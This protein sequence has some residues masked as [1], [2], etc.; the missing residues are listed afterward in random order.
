MKLSWPWRRCITRCAAAA[1]D[2]R[3]CT[4]QAIDGGWPRDGSRNEINRGRRTMGFLT[5][6]GRKFVNVADD[7][8]LGP[9]VSIFEFTNLYG[10]TMG[11]ERGI[12]TLLGGRGGATMAPVG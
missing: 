11:A 4:G 8:H 1:R 9:G 6:P 3:S 7:V 2:S 12:G 10:C 5:L